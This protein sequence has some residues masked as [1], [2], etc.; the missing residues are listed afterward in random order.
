[1]HDAIIANKLYTRPKQL[2][3]E[4]FSSPPKNAKP[5]NLRSTESHSSLKNL[6]LSIGRNMRL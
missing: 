6:I 1:M 4:G 3:R 2:H 5:G